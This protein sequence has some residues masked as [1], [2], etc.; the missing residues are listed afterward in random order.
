MLG[1]IRDDVE[2]VAALG[3]RVLCVQFFV[4]VGAAG[5]TGLV[6]ALVFLR[7]PLI[8]FEAA[9][10]VTDWSIVFIFVVV[11]GTIGAIKVPIPSVIVS[12]SCARRFPIWDRGTW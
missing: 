6:G 5:T 7:R 1:A 11:I 8:T 3:V 4:Y 2:V 9:F 10:S 12:W